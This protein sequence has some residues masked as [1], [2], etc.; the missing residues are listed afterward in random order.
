[1]KLRSIL[2]ACALTLGATAT[3]A[4]AA[5][6]PEGA[7]WSEATIPSA[8]GVQL[9]ADILRPSNL[10]AD[11]KTPVILSIGP[12][13]NHSGQT[14]AQGAPAYDP[15]GPS[16]GPNERFLDFI[17]GAKIF[18]RGYTWMQVD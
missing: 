2:V 10:P 5:P 14:G 16:E 15:V 8:D 11:A 3:T 18:E 9:H 6:V 13:F 17:E 7:T 12:Y 4:T 1:M